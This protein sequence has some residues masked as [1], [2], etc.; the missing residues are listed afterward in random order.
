MEVSR[1]R[2]ANASKSL[3]RRPLRSQAGADIRRGVDGGGVLGG[4]QQQLLVARQ[5]VRDA[6]EKATGAIGE[7]GVAELLKA[8]DPPV[9]VPAGARFF[10]AQPLA[11]AAVRAGLI[12][13][14]RAF[15]VGCPRH[16]AEGK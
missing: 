12:G 5:D 11:C 10:L 13:L 1:G 4:E 9:A 16:F 6:V 8:P 14:W 3:R 2:P 7:N 15:A